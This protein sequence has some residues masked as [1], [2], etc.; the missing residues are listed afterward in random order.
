MRL[1]LN[2]ESEIKSAMIA[3][4]QDSIECFES[5]QI[6]SFHWRKLK[7]RG[8]KRKSPKRTEMK[9]LT[10]AAKQAKRLLQKSMSIRVEPDLL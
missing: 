8:K 10:K 6:L 7:A 2:I 5:N 4:G 3:A 1:K 9:I